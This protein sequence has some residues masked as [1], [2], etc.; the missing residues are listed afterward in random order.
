MQFELLLATPDTWVETVFKDFN[1]FLSDHASAEK[2]ASG[3][4][5]SVAA[6]YPDKPKIVS[7]MVDL[8]VEELNHYR[9]VIRLILNRGL[10][11]LPD[12][13]DTYVKNLNSAIRRGSDFFLIDRLLV[14]GIIE[15][16]GSERFSLVAQKF[17]QTEPAIS[18]FYTSI[19]ASE[20]RHYSLFL[21]LAL[22]ACRSEAELFERLNELLELEANL[23]DELP[24]RPALH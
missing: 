17:A 1:T 24:T 10:N 5:L 9:Q 20:E 18:H 4:A 3:M 19:T 2:K 14:G 6:H 16:R 23:I 11:P 12:S 21:E 8:A 22:D 13:Q 15:K 7:A